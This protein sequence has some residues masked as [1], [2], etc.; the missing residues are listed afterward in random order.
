MSVNY[1]SM[2]AVNNVYKLFFSLFCFSLLCRDILGALGQPVL[3]YLS[4]L[5][6]IPLILLIVEFVE[7][8]RMTLGL[9]MLLLISLF[10]ILISTYNVNGIK[11]FIPM[12]YAGIAFRKMDFKYIVKYFLLIQIVCFSFRYWLIVSGLISE[13]EVDTIWKTEDG[14]LAHDLG[15][16]NSNAAGIALFY[17]LC[18]F[19]LLM[20]NKNKLISF[21][22]ILI[23]AS[24]FYNY[25]V[26][27]TALIS[28]ILLLITYLVPPKY[29][30]VFRNK[31]ILWLA[32][33]VVIS[34]LILLNYLLGISG[35]DQLL[36]GRLYYIS[37]LL[38]LFDDPMSLITGIE[39]DEDNSFAIDNVF[40]YMLVNGGVLAIIIFFW[41][42]RSFILSVNYVPV[43]IVAVILIMVMSGLGEAS[44]AA[45]GR[46]GSSFF[47][48][49]LLNRSYIKNNVGQIKAVN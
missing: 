5:F 18:A 20:Y 48:I 10:Y 39:I 16:G 7:K 23:S 22:I 19:Y 38:N 43:Y 44:W 25:T 2:I 45:F 21:I 33:I 9:F 14:R 40:S 11:L 27:R 3:L 47:W 24:L 42:Y 32:P 15:Y 37:Y 4:L 49:I 1:N 29:N 41:F 31:Y 13:N 35:L 26:S 17:L 34:P 12:I 28:T 30:S 6:L 36:S 8:R 46:L